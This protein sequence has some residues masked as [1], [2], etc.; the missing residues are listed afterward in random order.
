MNQAV[1]NERLAGNSKRNGGGVRRCGPQPAD[2]S[3][4]M[5]ATCSAE[6]HVCTNPILRGCILLFNKA[7]THEQLTTPKR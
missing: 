2:T 3:A 6:G 1:I 5:K 7:K 4:G